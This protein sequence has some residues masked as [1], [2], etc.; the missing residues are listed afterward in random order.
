VIFI[1]LFLL[2]P[3]C[4]LA[5]EG[6]LSIGLGYPY[7]SVKYDSLELKYATSEGI[8]VF[9][10]RFYYDFYQKENTKIFMGFEAGSIKFNTLDI[11]GSGYEGSLFI[12][13]EY[14]AT[15]KVSLMLDFSPTFINLKSDD[16]Y[17]ADGVE[18]VVNFAVY[19]YFSG[20]KE[21]EKPIPGK[22]IKSS[23]IDKKKELS[24]TE[25]KTLMKKHFGKATQ[26]YLQEKYK[27]AIAEWEKVI[28]INPSHNLSRQKIEKA[29]EKLTEE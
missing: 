8:D 16:D 2:V 21:K 27:E 7:V 1:L 14:F 29:K 20:E 28:E 13:G 23:S 9:A 26:L 22:I 18:M 12:G 19:Y 3:F 17:K 25:K 15:R 4:V 10:G 24:E 11:K 6:K 5:E